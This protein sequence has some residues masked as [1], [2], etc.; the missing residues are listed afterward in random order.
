VTGGVEPVGQPELSG[1]LRHVVVVVV[2]A[3]ADQEERVRD[4]LP[5]EGEG[6]EEAF[7]VLVR[8]PTARMNSAG[9]R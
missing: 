5:G 2:V 6:L 9:N 7:E 4:P 3:L 8:M 1:G